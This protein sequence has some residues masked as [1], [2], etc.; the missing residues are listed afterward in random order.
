MDL[1]KEGVRVLGVAESY[2]GDTSVL[3]GVVMRR[4]GRID[5]F[6]F[7][8]VTVGGLDST[9]AVKDLYTSLGREDL[10]AVLVSGLALAWYNVV[11]LDSVHRH[12]EIPVVCVTYEESPGLSG[13]IERE[14][15]GKERR[16][17][18]ELY[19]GQEERSRAELSTGETVYLRAVGLE[20][21]EAAD[22]VD[23]FTSHGGRPEPLRLAGLAARAVSDY[24]PDG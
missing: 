10:H 17:R 21:R 19:E 12:T 9:D 5:G 3:G 16:K 1:S 24:V 15:T 14:F 20:D 8:G 23:R 13:A 6:G 22:L 11:D 2:R 4:D 18:L 7:E